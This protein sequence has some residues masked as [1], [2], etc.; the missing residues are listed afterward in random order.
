[1]NAARERLTSEAAT[2]PPVEEQKPV[3]AHELTHAL[4]D[5]YVDLDKWQDPEPENVAKN[6]SEDNLH[7]RTDE[8]GTV[9]EAV[10]EP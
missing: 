4:Q 2:I 3:M 5:Q 10:L 6:V 1:M 7:I 9:R 8:A